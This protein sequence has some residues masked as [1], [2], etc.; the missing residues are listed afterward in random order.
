MAK[1]TAGANPNG[2]LSRP[3][4]DTSRIRNLMIRLR[5]SPIVNEPSGNCRTFGWIYSRQIYWRIRFRTVPT[6]EPFVQRP[7]YLAEASHNDLRPTKRRNRPTYHLSNL[8]FIC[9]VASHCQRLVCWNSQRIHSVIQGIGIDVGKRH[10]RPRLRKCPARRQLQQSLCCYST[11][12]RTDDLQSTARLRCKS[13]VT[14][15]AK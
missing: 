13:Q 3:V 7:L 5:G 14:Q 9:H 12:R 4:H 6:I 11:C 8:R 1:P 10:G 15:I 2:E